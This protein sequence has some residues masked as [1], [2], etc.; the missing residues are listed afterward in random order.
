MAKEDGKEGSDSRLASE[1]HRAMNKESRS[2]P[3][4]QFS[5]PLA[6]HQGYM[7]YMHGYPYGQSYDPNHPGYRGVPSVMMQNYPG[8]MLIDRNANIMRQN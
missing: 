8:M 4:M 6:Q 3:H 7:S 1:E 2:N 5:S